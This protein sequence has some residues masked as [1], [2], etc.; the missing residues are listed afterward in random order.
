MKKSLV[1][2]ALC[3]GG[4]LPVQAQDAQLEPLLITATRFESGI[5]SAP[6]NVTVIDRAEISRSA[7]DNLAGLLESRAGVHVNDL[8]GISGSKSRVDLGGFGGTGGLNTLILL[9]GRRL[10]DVDVSGANLAAIPLAAIERIEVIR[11]SSAVLYGDNAVGGVINIVTRDGFGTG[12]GEVELSTGSF[13]THRLSARLRGGDESAWSLAVAGLTSNGYRDRS[14]FDDASFAADWSR[15]YGDNLWG[16]RVN[17]HYEEMELP[18]ALNE[19]D[20]LADPTQAGTGALESTRE[21]SHGLEGFLAGETISAEL[22]WR[23]KHQ[24]ATIFG[25]TEADLATLSFTPRIRH[26]VGPHRLVAGIDLYHSELETSAFFPDTGWGANSNR[27]DLTR[28]SYAVYLTDAIAVTERLEANLGARWQSVRFDVDNLDRISGTRTTDGRKD[29]LSSWEAGL[30]FTHGNGG[31]SY[32]RL[33]ES[34]RFAVLDEVW[35]YFTGG[36]ALL[37]PQEGRHFEIGTRQPVAGGHVSASAFRIRLTDEIAFDEGQ[38]ANVNLDPTEHTGLDLELQLPLTSQL[39]LRGGYGLRRAE[40]REGAYSG[41]TVPEI[42][43][44]KANLAADYR[45]AS[46]G[47]FTLE[48]VYTGERYF[49]NDFDNIGK[50]MPGHTRFDAAWSRDFDHW[51]VGLTVKNLTDEKA[52]DSGFYSAW[53][54]N[55][56]FYY[57]LPERAW[58]LTVGATF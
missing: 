18:G 27:S 39:A 1:A 12:R 57:P 30:A 10:N 8:F 33:A 7:S 55:P 20:F 42:P 15:P 6:V 17:G 31:R 4:A 52:A 21:H 45:T 51:R 49:G 41:N 35:S 36:I 37:K 3:A 34:F 53:S 44:H 25:D 40:F 47:Q 32:L 2:A 58:Y 28:E 29:N 5:D 48:A 43:R 14:A 46:Y 54:A 22:A 19:P 50:R 38:F 13:D 11:G 9:N 16:F 56:Y 26:D 24:E 23:S